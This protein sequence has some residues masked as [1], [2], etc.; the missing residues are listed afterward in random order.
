M[1]AKIVVKNKSGNKTYL[2]KDEESYIVE[3]SEIYGA[4]GIQRDIVSFTNEIQ[5]V[6]HYVGKQIIGTV[7][8]PKYAKSYARRVIQRVNIEEEEAEE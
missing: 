3:T 2:L 4:H 6:L 7:I 1:T 5:Q 8:Q